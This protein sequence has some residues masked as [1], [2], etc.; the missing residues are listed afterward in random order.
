MRFESMEISASYNVAAVFKLNFNFL[1]IGFSKNYK[2]YA[3]IVGRSS[4]IPTEIKFVKTSFIH[5]QIYAVF[6]YELKNFSKIGDLCRKMEY[7]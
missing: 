2:N 3:Q 4:L 7:W 5:G 6:P 1:S